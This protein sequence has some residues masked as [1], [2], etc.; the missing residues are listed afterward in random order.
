M[1]KVTLLIVV[2]CVVSCPVGVL[3]NC[4]S[5]ETNEIFCDDF[6][7]YGSPCG[8][9][10]GGSKCT[11][12]ESRNDPLL[13]QTWLADP[14]PGV[15]GTEMLVTEGADWLM[16]PPFG[17]HHPCQGDAKSG[18]VTIRDWVHSAAISTGNHI[19]NMIWLIQNTFPGSN[20]VV[21]TDANPLH[22]DFLLNGKNSDKIHWNNGYFELTLGTDRAST[23]YFPGPD[24]NS[25][26]GIT[27]FEAMPIICA[28]GNPSGAMPAGCPNVATYPPPVR[29]SIAVGVLGMLDTNPCHCDAPY[30]QHGPKNTQLNVFDGQMWWT[31]T[32]DNPQPTTGTYESKDGAPMPPPNPG[33]LTTPGNFTMHGGYPGDLAHNW[34]SLTIKTNTFKVEMRTLEKD[35]AEPPNQYYV[36]SVMDNI[37][38]AYLGAFDAMRIGTGMGC[39]LA[40]NTSW[41]SCNGNTRYLRSRACCAGANVYDDI[42][43]HGGAGFSQPGA[44]CDPSNGTCTDDVISANC[45]SPKNFFGPGTA[46]STELC[47]ISP[48]ADGDADGDVDQQ[49]FGLWQ[50]CFSGSGITHG[51]GCDCYDRNNVSGAQG[52]DGD[53]DANDFAWFENCFSGPTVPLD[54]ENP[55]A[56]C[57]P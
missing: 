30:S 12:P 55:P 39:E 11:D 37:P 25:Y 51:A 47:C 23:N 18:Q 3:A 2:F 36:T 5:G 33:D 4:P 13:K 24:C 16:S 29:A 45:Q 52:G 27:G 50:A 14:F 9:H 17:G 20:A 1:R 22:L 7:T 43:L 57:V 48:F 8:G 28:Q 38:R 32:N 19:R 26:C 21:G 15:L 34:I 10:P 54:V 56:G 49:D 46:C 53:I 44:C 40:S 31:L 41:T 42:V 35:T 6:D